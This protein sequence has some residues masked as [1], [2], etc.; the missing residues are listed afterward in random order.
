M[1]LLQWEGGLSRERL[2]NV[3]LI[4]HYCVIC[5]SLSLWSGY[6]TQ[7]RRDQRARL[8][9]KMLGSLRFDWVG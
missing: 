5:S 4:A 8:G 2:I 9:H 1:T 7:A 6:H 3:R